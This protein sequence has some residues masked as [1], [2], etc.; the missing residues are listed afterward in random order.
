MSAQRSEKAQVFGESGRR[1]PRWQWCNMRLGRWEGE[2][3]GWA[4]QGLAD[5]GQDCEFYPYIQWKNRKAF[6]W[7]NDI[8]FVF[9]QSHLGCC[10]ESK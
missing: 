2:R 10:G 6:K 1:P 3:V 5:E 9:F 7:G 4:K 8:R